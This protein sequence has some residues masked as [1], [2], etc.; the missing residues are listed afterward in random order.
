[1]LRVLLQGRAPDVIYI[2]A[3][4]DGYGNG[5]DFAACSI[6]TKGRAQSDMIEHFTKELLEQCPLGGPQKTVILLRYPT[7]E[8][9]L[10]TAVQLKG[11][12]G[13]RTIKECE[14]PIIPEDDF[15]DTDHETVGTCSPSPSSANASAAGQSVGALASNEDKGA[16]V[17]LDRQAETS[18]PTT[19]VGEVSKGSQRAKPY[20]Y[21]GQPIE[22][23]L[24]KQYEAELNKRLK[25][26]KM[27]RS[28]K[29]LKNSL[30]NSQ[31]ASRS[32][33]QLAP[34]LVQEYVYAI[35]RNGKRAST[36][37]ACSTYTLGTPLRKRIKQKYFQ[38]EHMRLLMLS[39]KKDSPLSA[40]SSDL[41]LG[42]LKEIFETVGLRA[43]GKIVILSSGE[44]NCNSVLAAVGSIGATA[45][46][47][48]RL[49]RLEDYSKLE[50]KII[51]G[52]KEGIRDR[53]F[54]PCNPLPHRQVNEPVSFVLGAV[55][56]VVQLVEDRTMTREEELEFEKKELNIRDTVVPLHH[57]VDV[58]FS[59]WREH[60]LEIVND[61]LRSLE[62]DDSLF[63]ETLRTFKMNISCY[64]R[65]GESW[66]HTT[67]TFEKDEELF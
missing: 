12:F 20:W 56:Q 59:K 36:G 30:K 9:G 42:T 58:T 11:A 14:L 5:S 43:G 41:S 27:K 28:P 15:D 46:L 44:N 49:S 16:E 4:D 61:R 37:R 2:D 19:G 25:K 39:A 66:L 65:G 3:V 17:S 45:I 13:L 24:Q 52:L 23:H 38:K 32:R 21:I 67:R 35:Q 7:A 60:P 64:T 22:L 47:P 18:I 62:A 51:D 29:D 26:Y 31:T 33:R 63:D 54:K 10:C 34:P 53:A 50:N 40:K 48:M 1:M 8:T 55:R 57:V 6:P